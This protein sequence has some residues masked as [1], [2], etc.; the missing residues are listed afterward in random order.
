MKM[1]VKELIELLSQY[2]DEMKVVVDGYEGG[3]SDIS[4]IGEIEI[5]KLPLNKESWYG[6]YRG[7]DE[8][9]GYGNRDIELEKAI[10]LPRD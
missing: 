9:Y 3:Y 6:N 2:P 8:I 5:S 4:D 10:L 1:N 7:K